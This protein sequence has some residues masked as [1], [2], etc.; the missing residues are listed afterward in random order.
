MKTIK[1]P[2]IFLPQFVGD[3]APFN[4]LNDIA[5]WAALANS[6]ERGGSTDERIGRMMRDFVAKITKWPRGV[7]L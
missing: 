2:A 5:R 1:G 3:Q 4:N 6:R 7:E